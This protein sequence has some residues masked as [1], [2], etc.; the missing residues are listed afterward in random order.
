MRTDLDYPCIQLHSIELNRLA[1]HSFEPGTKRN[2][3][4]SIDRLAMISEP[5]SRNGSRRGYKMATTIGIVLFLFVIGMPTSICFCEAQSDHN[6][7][8]D[9][10]SGFCIS[11]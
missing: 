2:E 7:C 10:V 9:V 1:L 11:R 3:A 5:F 4:R 6:C 8:V